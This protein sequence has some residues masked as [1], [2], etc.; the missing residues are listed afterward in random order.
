M[1]DEPI[2]RQIENEIRQH[3]QQNAQAEHLERV[4]AAQHHQ[5]SQPGG[6][7]TRVAR[8]IRIGHDRQGQHAQQTGGG[9]H[10]FLEPRIRQN[11]VLRKPAAGFVQRPGQDDHARDEGE[12]QRG[13]G[14]PSRGRQIARA[15]GARVSQT[16]R[17]GEQELPGERVEEPPT[18]LGEAGHVPAK[19][20]RRGV[21]DGRW[22]QT[23][24]NM[25]PDAENEERQHQKQG[26]V[27]R[28]NVQQGRLE[29]QQ[30]HA[31]EGFSRIFQV[32]ADLKLIRE[33]RVVEEF[34]RIRDLGVEDHEQAQMRDVQLPDTP[35]NAREP[36][37]H[38]FPPEHRSIRQGGGVAGDENE[39]LGGVAER[40]GTQGEVADGVVG[41]VID[42][43][44]DQR[45]PAEEVEAVIAFPAF[46][47]GRRGISRRVD[48]GTGAHRPRSAFP[49]RAVR[50]MC[51]T[52]GMTA[53]VAHAQGPCARAMNGAALSYA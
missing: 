25:P 48:L 24:K 39:H 21:E 12:H 31:D 15:L 28:E 50:T 10:G 27:K 29:L 43:D 19:Q 37:R 7:E 33:Q 4:L 40:E 36:H 23:P 16:D 46:A 3:R 38:A 30:Q 6:D 47:R 35:V 41:D 49:V 18:P 44:E 20:V 53:S 34:Q 17:D 51:P 32:I 9:Q 52:R 2:T 13:G 45:E 5:P 26:D 22:D 14:K 1:H 42:E 8:D 11:D